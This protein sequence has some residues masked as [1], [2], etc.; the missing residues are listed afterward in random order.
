MSKVMKIL[1]KEHSNSM[2][3][4]ANAIQY[5]PFKKEIKKLDLSPNINRI[6][7]YKIFKY[8][9]KEDNL[10]CRCNNSITGNNCGNHVFGK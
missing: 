10:Y 3:Y 2:S 7:A 5:I 4:G 6:S 9:I 8:V 1:S